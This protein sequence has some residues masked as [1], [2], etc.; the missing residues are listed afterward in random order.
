[1]EYERM[2]KVILRKRADTVRTEEFV[3]IEHV[4]QN[5]LQLFLVD[6]RQQPTASEADECF[7]SRGNMFHH[8]GV[9]LAEQLNEFPQPG[10]TLEDVRLKH[11]GGA[12]RQ[13]SRSE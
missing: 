8:L 13:Q 1:M 4:A 11:S 3:L 12:Q 10:M 2:P 6:G 5:A 7:V 9:A